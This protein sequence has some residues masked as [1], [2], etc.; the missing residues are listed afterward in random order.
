MADGYAQASGQLA[1]ANVHVQ[2][3]M[4]NALAGVLNAARARVPLLVTVGQ[5]VSQM[6]PGEPFLGGDVLGMARPLA[7]AVY[8]PTSREQL[9]DDVRSAIGVALSPPRGPVV[10]SLPLE[11]QAGPAPPASYHPHAASSPAAPS[12]ERIATA[13][14]LLRAARL[15]VLIAGDGVADAGGAGELARLAAR[16]GAPVFGEP[17]AARVAMAWNRPL[18]SGQLQPF[19]DEIRRALEP[20]DLVL[21]VGMP[22][23]RLFGHSPAAPLPEGITLIHAEV[24][25]REVGKTHPPDVGLVGDPRL[26]LAALLEALGPSD[27][28]TR[29]RAAAARAAIAE[30]RRVVRARAIASSGGPG[31]PPAAFAK[32][33]AG[34]VGPNDLVVDEAVTSGR[35]LRALVSSRRPGTWLAHRGSAL[36]WGLPAAVGA[37]MARPRQRVMS[38]H[39]DGGLLFGI[40]ALWTAAQKRTPLALAVA[41]NR[42]YEILRAGLEGF[43]GTPQAD[44]PGLWLED[45][46]IDIAGLISAYGASVVSVG[47]AGE[48]REAF[49]DLWDR[50]A[51][52]PAALVVRVSGRTPS[53]GHPLP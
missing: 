15:P 19:G 39:G 51:G 50:A 53:V 34:T 41:D 38:L 42:G 3:G 27:A 17:M 8:E 12:A 46:A 7:K 49:S 11:V 36:G 6:L 43:T 32:A 18:W 2:P 24:D 14:R 1:A 29:A 35:A 40:Q 4:A 5:Q 48:L 10:L 31:I 16:L 44:W 26:A 45:P 52:G 47:E 23:F 20:H 28:S 22:L 30:R 33:V 21:A 13:A 25:G 9:A 37:A